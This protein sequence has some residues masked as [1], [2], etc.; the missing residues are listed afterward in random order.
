MNAE[1]HRDFAIESGHASAPTGYAAFAVTL[2]E[3]PRVDVEGRA[4]IVAYDGHAEIGAIEVVS[5]WHRSVSTG[6][7]IYH[8]QPVTGT[9]LGNLLDAAIRAKLDGA[10]LDGKAQA[11]RDQR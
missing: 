6:L 5:G 11:V 4:E 9:P 10:W 3:L 8:Y 1:T 2:D 7:L